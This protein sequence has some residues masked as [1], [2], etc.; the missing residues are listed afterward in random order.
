MRLIVGTDTFAPDVNGA[1]YFTQHLASGLAGRGHEVHVLCPSTGHR[2]ADRRRADGVIEHRVPAVRTPFHPTFRVVVPPSAARCARRLVGEIDPDV[3]HVQGHFPIGRGLLRA[4][5]DTGVPVVGT[6]HFMPENLLGYLPWLPAAVAGRMAS[7][8]W[9]DFVRVFNDADLVTT[10][11]PIAAALL[12]PLRMRPPVLAVSCG[13][14]LDRFYP[15]LRAES[16]WRGLPQKPTILFVGRLDVEKR[17]TDLIDALAI[18]RDAVD[19]QL[20]LVGTGGQRKALAAR[21]VAAGVADD[22][23][24]CGFVPDHELPEAYAACDVFANAGVAE[25]QSLVTMEA[26]ASGRPVVAADAVALPHLVQHGRNGFRFPPGD[27]TTAAAHLRS[28]LTDERLRMRMGA[29]SRDLIAGHSL[30]ASLQRFEELYVAAAEQRR[31]PAT[32]AA[33]A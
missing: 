4:A 26:M 33:A 15:R 8:A 31:A 9:R 6:N 17:I 24:F 18:V 13:V 2:P 12:E 10:P 11:T 19:A 3:V 1:S 14:Q 28:V 30:H 32:A 23:H 20:V 27:V 25:L 29:A 22:V 21:A 5:R 7:W 16:R